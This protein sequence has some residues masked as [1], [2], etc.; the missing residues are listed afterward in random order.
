MLIPG[1]VSAAAA[2]VLKNPEPIVIPATPKAE[3][4]KKPLRDRF[5][6]CILVL[7]NKL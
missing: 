3:F 4:F 7:I 1:L 6:F 2:A 5:E